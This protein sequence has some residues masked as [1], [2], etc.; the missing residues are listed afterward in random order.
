MKFDEAEQVSSICWQLRQGDLI[1]GADRARINSLFNGAPPYSPQEVEENE[2]AVNV[3]SLESCVI[4]HDAR[5]QYYQAFLKPGNFFKLRT[6][7]G[8]V[9]KREKYSAIVTK[10]IN[11]PMKRSLTYFE[12]L[13]SK[14]ANNVLHGIGPATWPDRD[15]WNPRARGVE[16]LLIPADTILSFEDLPFFAVLK[17]YTAPE[18]IRLTRGAKT[19]PAWNQDLVKSALEWIDK[20]TMAMLGQTYATLYSPEKVEE[21][22]KGD[23][24]YYAGDQVPRLDTFDFYYWSDEGD[25][26]GWRRR[27]IIDD[28]STPAG[29]ITANSKLTRNDKLDFG[30]DQWLY[31]SGSRKFA[32]KRDEIFT[33]QFA[34]LSAVGPF[35]Y[36]SVRSLGYLMFAICH[37]QN[38]LRCKFQES[39]MEALMMLFRVKS[40]EDVQRVL[41]TNLINKGFVDEA[42]TFIPAAERWQVNA[43]LVELGLRENQSIIAKNSSSYTQNPTVMQ[44][45]VEKTATQFQGELASMTTLVSAALTQAYYYQGSEANEIVRRFMRDKSTDP[46]VRAARASILKQGVPEKLLTPEQWECEMERVMS[47]SKAMEMAIAEW[48]MTHR[49]KYDPEAQREILRDVTLAVTDDPAKADR[50][51]PEQP[52][53]SDSIHDAQLTFGSLMQLGIVSVRPGLNELEYIPAMLASMAAVVQQIEQSGGMT[54]PKT[55]AGLNNVAQNVGQHIQ[56][57]AQDESSKQMVKQFADQLGQIGNLLKGYAQ[58]LQEQAQKQNGN[59]QPDPE[60]MAKI[61]ATMLTAQAKAENARESHAQKTA[62]RQISFEMK[63]QQEQAKHSL[64]LQKQA[65]LTA[66]EVASKA[67]LTAAEV[68]AQKVKAENAPAPKAAE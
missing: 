14:F 3:N 43:N 20:E 37:L 19:D 8:A 41:K 59:G 66:T 46:D 11:R 45:R 27:I 49:D 57:L 39:V 23:G 36:H 53:I 17:S 50:L 7:A 47:P 30:R 52:H 16:D 2:I 48:L 6:D 34:D 62:Q 56:I 40:Q 38:R 1:R 22:I 42:L 9:H 10:A 13:R 31:N 68:E 26:Y 32:D 33:C 64:D 63:T 28:W 60:A 35:H 4:G 18:L 15:C 67:A 44:D 58:R 12:T 65:Q 24:G 61:Q 55:L 51:V 5:S 21:R 25:D 54:D 29:K